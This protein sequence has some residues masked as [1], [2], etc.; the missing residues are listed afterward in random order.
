MQR[1]PVDSSY[2]SEIGFD[3]GILEVAY[4]NGKVFRYLNVPSD[5][6]KSVLDSDSIG[7]AV[8]EHI[9]QGGFE[10]EKVEPE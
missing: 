6:H 1:S 8:R 3:E 10:V 7:R 2:V 9:V 4:K 5:T